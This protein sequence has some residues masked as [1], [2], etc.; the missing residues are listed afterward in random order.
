MTRLAVIAAA[1]HDRTTVDAMV[2]ESRGQLSELNSQLDAMAAS[3]NPNVKSAASDFKKLMVLWGEQAEK[4]WTAAEAP[5][6]HRGGHGRKRSQRIQRESRGNSPRIFDAEVDEM[7]QHKAE[8][9]S[10]VATSQMIL[11]G[12][13][14]WRRWSWRLHLRDSRYQR[15][16]SAERSPI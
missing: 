3:E 14:S 6:L 8:G 12:D 11:V 7:A 2:K 1:R 9:S 4:T 10:L 5:R 13:S 16:A 15:H